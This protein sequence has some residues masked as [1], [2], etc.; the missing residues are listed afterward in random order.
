MPPGMYPP[1]R[2]VPQQE[3]EDDPEG[4]PEEE[5]ARDY[6]RVR[7]GVIQLRGVHGYPIGM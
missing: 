7:E 4:H 3:R 5:H 2:E 1:S 6:F